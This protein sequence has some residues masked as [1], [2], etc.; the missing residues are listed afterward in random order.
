MPR[1]LAALL[2]LAA[3]GPRASGAE[4][5][6]ELKGFDVYRSQTLTP[7]KVRASV[8]RDFDQFLRAKAD[9]RKSSAANAERLEAALE[10][11]VK[12][13]APLA[14][15]R[16]SYSQYVSSAERS[17]YVVFDV[18]DS[19]DAARR[20]AFKAA[21]KGSFADPA[22]L[23]AAWRAYGE[24][25]RGLL[26]DGKL[27]T[28]HQDCPAHYCLWGSATPE[29]ADYERRFVSGAAANSAA[30]L[31]LVSGDADPAKRAAA[32]LVLSY[33][34]DSKSYLAVVTAALEDP[35][36]EVRSAAL[37]I[38]S[39]VALYRK[40]LVLDITKIVP[41]LDDPETSVRAKALAVLVGLAENSAYRTYIIVKGGPLLV[42]LL[43]L[44]EP[45]NHD[46][47]FTILSLLS[48]E[49]YGRRDYKSWDAWVASQSSAT[50]AG[51]GP[52]K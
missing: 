46:L 32:L 9:P 44:H 38:L 6:I 17:A 16:L 31:Q 39:D 18:V 43:K 37:L 10:A 47:A 34:T 42:G 50:A 22:G 30:L 8:G 3:L 24:L 7:E 14:F 51:S 29:L 35:A 1:L 21:P 11:G 49:T 20:L 45:S 36:E 25:G 52:N 27:S 33:T 40:S 19:T 26:R 12:K 2:L 23:L 13:L 5:E 28:D 48:K 15:V 41:T 4:D